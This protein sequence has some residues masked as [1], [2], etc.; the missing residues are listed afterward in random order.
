MDDSTRVALANDDI[1]AAAAWSGL[2]I[3]TLSNQWTNYKKN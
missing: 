1:T 2:P 3:C